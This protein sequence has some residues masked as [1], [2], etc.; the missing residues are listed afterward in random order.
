MRR[1]RASCSFINEIGRAR[2]ARYSL[3]PLAETGFNYR[4]TAY[5][6][7]EHFFGLLYLDTS[8]IIRSKIFFLESV[9]FQFMPACSAQR[10]HSH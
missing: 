8:G 9:T 5:K 4:L 6:I 7:V 1:G 10:S 3:A 2:Q